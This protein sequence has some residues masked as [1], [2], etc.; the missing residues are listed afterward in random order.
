MTE[1]PQ[2]GDLCEE[3]AHRS[4]ERLF[5]RDFESDAV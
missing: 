4:G 1:Q 2:L 5:P 3:V